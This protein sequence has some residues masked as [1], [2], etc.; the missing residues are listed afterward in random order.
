LNC[1]C[2]PKRSLNRVD[3]EIHHESSTHGLS[4]LIR[5]QWELLA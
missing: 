4:E 3:D 5:E 1:R 2:M